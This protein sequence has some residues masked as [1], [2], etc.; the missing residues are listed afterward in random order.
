MA[1]HFFGHDIQDSTCHWSFGV[2]CS[3]VPMVIYK[4]QIT[5][6]DGSLVTV[7]ESCNKKMRSFSTYDL[8]T[9]EV[10]VSLKHESRL[11]AQ[12]GP[13]LVPKVELTLVFLTLDYLAY[14]PD[15]VSGSLFPTTESFPWSYVWLGFFPE[16]Y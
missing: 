14:L 7:L 8:S 9:R 13:G 4:Q 2:P 11:E 16:L 1:R 10:V 5:P 6:Q 3:Q 15:E 12:E